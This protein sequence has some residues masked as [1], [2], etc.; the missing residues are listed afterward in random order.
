MI[1]V[2]VQPEVEWGSPPPAMRYRKPKIKRVHRAQAF[3]EMLKERPGE[4]CKYPWPLASSTSNY[5]LKVRY[6]GTVWQRRVRPDGKFDIWG[7][8]EQP[9]NNWA[10]P[11]G[12]SVRLL[13]EL[14]LTTRTRNCLKR[15]KIYTVEAVEQMSNRE[16]LCIPY[17][18][19]GSLWDLR[20]AVAQYSTIS[21]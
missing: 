19:V 21:P 18:G 13:D 8:W 14:D 15:A 17:F 4:D 6:P 20:N 11:S 16:L 7:R 3:V 12:Q 9:R 1:E 10:P 5:S 2:E